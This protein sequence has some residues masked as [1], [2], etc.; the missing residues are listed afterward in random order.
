MSM[1]AIVTRAVNSCKRDYIK[2]SSYLNWNFTRT[3]LVCILSANETQL[4][5][6]RSF[7]TCSLRHRGNYCRSGEERNMQAVNVPHLHVVFLSASLLISIARGWVAR[8]A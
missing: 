1:C 8:A 3:I 2:N 4:K 5:T 7:G 6:R